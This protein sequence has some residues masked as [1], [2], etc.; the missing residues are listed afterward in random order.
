[1]P[2]SDDSGGVGFPGRMGNPNAGTSIQEL[3]QALMA[4]AMSRGAPPAEDNFSI[5]DLMQSLSGGSGPG[6]SQNVPM[7]ASNPFAKLFSSNPGTGDSTPT[8]PGQDD[9]MTNLL[10]G[11][12]AGGGGNSPSGPEAPQM[13]PQDMQLQQL[14]ELNEMLMGSMGSGESL[15]AALDQAT[16]GINQSYGSQIGLLKQQNAG[17]RADT[18]RGTKQIQNMYAALDREYQKSAKREKKWGMKAAQEIEGLGTRQAE[19]INSN[20]NDLLLQNAA[21]AKELESPELASQLNSDVVDQSAELG[22]R[23]IFNAG[24]SAGTQQK[25]TNLNTGYLQRTGQNMELE[26]RNRAADLLGQLQ[27]YLQGNR[28]KIGDI[29]G[30]R[31]AALA[32]AQSQIS[33]SYENNQS[34]ILQQVF[35]N[36]MAMSKLN[37]DMQQAQQQG[38]GENPLEGLLPE[39]MMKSNQLM[40]MATPQLQEIFRGLSD[41]N[42]I[43]NNQWEGQELS[44]N[45]PLLQKYVADHMTKHPDDFGGSSWNMLGGA[46][47]ATLIAAL[48]QLLSGSPQYNQPDSF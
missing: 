44:G 28:A 31:A 3:L 34:D 1:M 46:D 42:S 11:P 8:I 32:Q 24:T 48:F 12:L 6:P 40:G 36:A 37:M 26:G 10:L 9:A 45:L 18:K 22:N 16:K 21:A 2:Y 13:S 25:Y 38:A 7:P 30:Q 17:A 23:A 41:N 19:N 35:D 15:Q 29:A 43:V 20:A 14:S 5:R 47:Q 4:D 33:G 39:G 27:D